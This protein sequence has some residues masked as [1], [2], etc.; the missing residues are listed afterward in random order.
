MLGAKVFSFG[1]PDCNAYDPESVAAAPD[2]KH[3]FVLNVTY[4][5]GTYKN[6]RMDVTEEVRALPLGGVIPLEIDVDD[7]P[8]EG[9]TGG[10]GF[11]ALVGDWNEETGSTTIIN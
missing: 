5:N 4:V 8:P 10:G 9:G 7:F 3:Y 6:I 1:I 11:N 2:G